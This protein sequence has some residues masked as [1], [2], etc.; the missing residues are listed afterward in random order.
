MTK[1]KR[2]ILLVNT[3]ME[4]SPYPVPPVGL[5]LLSAALEE[6]F[7]VKIYDGVFDEGAGLIA[8]VNSFNP[9]FIGFSIR[10]IDDVVAD[11][12]IFY[13][14]AIM[15]NFI[16]PLKR[17]T[18]VPVIL[19]GSGFSIFPEELMRITGA[20]Y[21]IVGEGE[22]ILPVLL[23]RIITGETVVGI[24]H[25]ITAKDLKIATGSLLPQVSINRSGFS[26]IDRRI[27]F[28]PYR[29]KGVYSIQTKRGCSHGCIYCTYP[30]IEGRKFRARPAAE[31]ADEIDQVYRRLG[32]VTIEFVDS[33]FNDP[34]GHA[35]EICREIIRRKPDVN[36]RTMGMNPRHCS[37]E[38]LELMIAAGFKQIDAT[39]DT[40]SPAMLKSL[41]K[42]FHLDEIEKMAGL[43]KKFNLPTMWFFLF[44]GPGENEAT[45]GESVDFI[46]SFVNPEDLVYMAAGLRIY[47]HTPLYNIAVGEGRIR[48][49]ESVLYPPVYYFAEELGKTGLDRLIAATARELPN[50]VP[51]VETAPPA[52]M[53]KEALE[54]RKLTGVVEPMFR[55][56]L[57]IRRRWRG[58][59]RI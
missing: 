48:R 30:H 20:D 55:T 7:T 47:P 33:T 27:D 42:G 43:I 51:A 3:N 26:E 15:K 9:G 54:Y 11:R 58:E 23:D 53:V 49:G 4:R 50:C 39:P 1:E 18:D 2:K 21:G 38:L 40:A 14:D 17:V 56:M 29:T 22:A 13:I 46:R 12:S 24:P 34:K 32:N 52:E 6:Q 16:L 35:E 28:T 57:R 59:G 31:I 8:L 37:E 25:V 19:G 5:C 36:L 10:N 44:G 41:A 45:F